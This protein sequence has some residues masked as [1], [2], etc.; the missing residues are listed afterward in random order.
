MA[1]P[2]GRETPLGHRLHG[3]SIDPARALEE[4]LLMHLPV[5]ALAR[6]LAGD[7]AFSHFASA[8]PGLRELLTMG[9]LWYLGSDGASRA[10]PYDVVIADLP[11]TGHGLAMLRAP[12]TFSDIASS[13]PL[14]RQTARV[15]HDLTDPKRTAAVIVTL[16]Q[17]VPVN[18][19]LELARELRAMRIRAALGIANAVPAALVEPS[20]L[21]ALEAL[22]DDGD[23]SLATVAARAAIERGHADIERDH[24]I[25][26]LRQG[27]LAVTTLPDVAPTDRRDLRRL[28]DALKEAW[29]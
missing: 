25:E 12:A 27:G 17:E 19:S 22:G 5:P 21:Q 20:D 7:H 2:S 23:E 18:E 29:C 15:A 1:E 26:R 6:R 8:A 14:H 4:Y 10:A 3:L 13:G 9:K 24:Q 28:A 16:A 11:A